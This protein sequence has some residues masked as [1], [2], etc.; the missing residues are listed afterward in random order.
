MAKG[1]LGKGLSALIPSVAETKKVRIE[2]IPINEIEF[3]PNQPRKHF[4]QETFQ[5]LVSSIKEF[6]VIQPIVVRPKGAS[7][8]VVAGERRLKAAKEAGLKVVPAVIKKSS[9]SESLEI[10]LIENLQ[11]ED[12]NAVEE[13]E[14]YRQLLEKFNLTQ[15]ELAEKVGKGRATITNAL[16]ILALPQSIKQLIIDGKLS[17]G[18]ARAL[19]SLSEESKQVKLAERIITEGLTVRQTESLV[20]IWQIIPK[21]YQKP[22]QPEVF[23]SFSKMLSESLSARVRVKMGSKRGKIEI[24]FKN[25]K[26]FERISQLLLSEDRNKS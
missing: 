10:A 26:D 13:A 15:E 12:L 24:T 6:G 19:L 20:K 25:L 3:N 1:G 8:E 18:H 2:E 7:Y 11:R 14:A 21:P 5:E 16:R 23:Q 4:D 22:P 9:D 17:S